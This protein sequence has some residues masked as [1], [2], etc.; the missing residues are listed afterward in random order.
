MGFQLD[1]VFSIS[2]FMCQTV[3]QPQAEEQSDYETT[4]VIRLSVQ[5]E[6]ASG[7]MS[8]LHC[9]WS[10]CSS[11]SCDQPVPKADPHYTDK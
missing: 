5:R 1:C 6:R 9:D 11:K 10:V 7:I 8:T 2:S 3:M 4:S